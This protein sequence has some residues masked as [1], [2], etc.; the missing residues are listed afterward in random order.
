[1]TASSKNPRD[2]AY[3]NASPVNPF[4]TLDDLRAVLRRGNRNGD[5]YLN[6][7]LAGDYFSGK[8]IW[9]NEDPTVR[10]IYED[11]LSACPHLYSDS[12]FNPLFSRERVKQP[13]ENPVFISRIC[14]AKQSY[15]DSVKEHQAVIA[16]GRGQSR[17]LFCGGPAPK[18]ASLLL[19]LNAGSKNI[20]V[21]FLFDGPEQSNESGSASYEHINHANALNAEYANTALGMLPQVIKR[22]LFGEPAV[23]EVLDPDFKRLDLWPSAVRVRDIPVYLKYEVHGLVQQIRKLLGI[24]NDHDKSRMASK[25]STRVLDYIE[26][27][28]GIKLRLQSKTPR[29]LF[30]ALSKSQHRASIKE[31]AH[32]GE[33]LGLYPQQLSE[34]EI[35]KFFGSSG[36][37]NICS[38]DLFRENNCLTHGFDT[39]ISQIAMQLKM[40]YRK[41]LRIKEVFI[42]GSD[43]TGAQ[44]KVVGVLLSKQNEEADTF[45]PIDY[46]G[47]SLGASA[48]YE[49]KSPEVPRGG[50]QPGVLGSPVPHQIMA[51][52]FTGQILF[53]ITDPK[54]F[55]EL[56]H[57]GLK[58]IHFVEM[59]KNAEYLLVKLTSGGNIGLPTY[60]RSYPISALAGML[61]V[62]TPD[63]GLEYV[64]TVC[65][66]PCIRGV[67]GSNNGEIVRITENMV[68]R[69]GEGGTGMSKMGSNA[70]IMLDMLGLDHALGSDAIT[71]PSLYQ[72]TVIDNRKKTRKWLGR[73]PC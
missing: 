65:A 43:D 10:Q 40:D 18:I 59:A 54:K 21:S 66:W 32:L 61:R 71:Q 68:V 55:N 44:P 26:K 5:A 69:F 60:S 1:M 29:G 58:Q 49:Y 41:G 48:T 25:R 24:R 19:A 15:Q 42:D 12:P 70:Q 14:D 6:Y 23:R 73:H 63:C 9:V 8:G 3:F 16:S 39:R 50:W 45:M 64:D 37:N 33:S 11:I 20:A 52:G 67:N 4:V 62:L 56:P 28:T 51:T 72:H 47:L 22:A 31:N 46:L 38:V 35:V 17:A 2:N 27:K 7:L 30:V 34:H 57:T 53:R 36:L 13:G